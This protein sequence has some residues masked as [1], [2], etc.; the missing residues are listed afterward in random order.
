MMSV[1]RELDEADR[2]RDSSSEASSDVDQED[3]TVESLVAGRQK[4]ATAG[5]RLSTLLGKEADDELELLFAEDDED[6]EFEGVEGV[7]ADEQSDVQFDSSDDGDEDHQGAGERADDDLEGEREL[8]K[9][10]RLDRQAKKRKAQE[11]FFKPPALRKRVKVDPTTATEAPSTSAS[12]P[13]KKSERVSWIPETGDGPT[14]SSSRKATVQNKQ[15]VHARMKE[16]EKRRLHQI[17]I[18][19]AAAKR[20]EKTKPRVMTQADRLAEA[21]RTEKLNSKSL[22]RWEEMEK[23]RAEEQAARLAA[24]Q[25]RH[26]DG[27]VITWWS[28]LAE[29]VNGKMRRVGNKRKVELLD[30][31]DRTGNGKPSD[32]RMVK[33]VKEIK[34]GKEVTDAAVTITVKPAIDTPPATTQEN[35]PESIAVDATQPQSQSQIQ[36]RQPQPEPGLPLI[37]PQPASGTPNAANKSQSPASS[38]DST[39]THHDGEPPGNSQEVTQASEQ[40]KIYNDQAPGLVNNPVPR[41]S[42]T[43]ERAA[44]NLVVLENFD[45]VAI[46]DRGVQRRILFKQRTL[47]PQSKSASFT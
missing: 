34:E 33:E 38:P 41:P 23:K 42:L 8:Q 35:Q 6:V 19:D 24:L 43:V 46:K 30:A 29:W 25:N 20:K 11:S 5:N 14:R 36:S 31:T 17:A 15:V 47:K 45:P 9:L 7:E 21:E 2:P 32:H 4:R 10:A 22:N 37:P 12:R 44:R 26:L 39:S 13:K 3:V 28:G 27:P 40:P 16:H 1:T 18:M